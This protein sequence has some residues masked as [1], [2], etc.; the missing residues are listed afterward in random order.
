SC[1]AAPR[2]LFDQLEGCPRSRQRSVAAHSVAKLRQKIRVPLFPKEQTGPPADPARMPQPPKD[3]PV[4]IE[5]PA[6][7]A[8]SS[9]PIRLFPPRFSQ[10]RFSQPRFS[11]QVPFPTVAGQWPLRGTAEVPPTPVAN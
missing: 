2:P 8:A 11:Q 4:S 10:P 5:L 7:A 9:F 3:R 1:C 6:P